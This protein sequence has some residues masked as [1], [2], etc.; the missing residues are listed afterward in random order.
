MMILACARC[1]PLHLNLPPV[2]NVRTI[3]SVLSFLALPHDAYALDPARRLSQYVHRIWQVQQGLPQASI[4]SLVQTHDGYLWLGTQTGL[5][6][7]DGARFTTIDDLSGVSSP[8]VWV[9][10]L[11]EDDQSSLWVGTNQAGLIRLQHGAVS[12]YSQREGLPSETVQCL[13]NDRLGNVWVCTPN[14]LAELTRGQVRVLSTAEG[15]ASPD[16]HA[17]CA[18]RDGT[19]IVGAGNSQIATWNGGRHRHAAG[20]PEQRRVRLH[21]RQLHRANADLVPLPARRI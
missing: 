16:I 3:L 10:H 1:R 21:G 13:F 15:L 14:G 2:I 8:D 11:M 6:R 4:Y 18:A 20:R 17:A 19:L 5:V 9:T 7:F 12:R